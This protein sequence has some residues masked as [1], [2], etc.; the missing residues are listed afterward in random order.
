MTKR[1]ILLMS[2]LM[3]AVIGCGGGERATQGNSESDEDRLNGSAT[4][5]EAV[6]AI[7][8]ALL[9]RDEETFLASFHADEMNQQ[10]LRGMFTLSC[11]VS[12]LNEKVTEAFGEGEAARILKQQKDPFDQFKAAT[13]EGLD[14]SAS[15]DG[16]SALCKFTDS[17]ADELMLTKMPDG[18]VGI[19]LS[20]EETMDEETKRALKMFEALTKALGEAGD[21]AAEEGMTVGKFEDILDAKLAGVY[22]AM[23]METAG[24]GE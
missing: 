13:E 6:M 14:I 10:I 1:L 11:A 2:V 19:V 7:R 18:W 16:Y 22:S 17:D 3:L 21:A 24:E 23:L 5:E 9:A 12:E 4:P 20:E 8:D 15:Q